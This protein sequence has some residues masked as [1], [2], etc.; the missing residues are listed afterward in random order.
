MTYKCIAALALLSPVA[1]F[2]DF[3]PA[4]PSV[5]TVGQTL[6][7]DNGTISTSGGDIQFAGGKLVPVSN[8]AGLTVANSITTSLG[9]SLIDEATICALA[10]LF[11][12]TPITPSLDAVIAI[13]TNAG[14]YSKLWLTAVSAS[15]VTIQFTTYSSGCS[16]GG[17]GG[18][19][20]GTG[21]STGGSGGT[22]GGPAIAAQGVKN[23][24]S[25]AD[26]R[27]PDGSIAQGSIFVVFGSAMGPSKIQYAGF[28]LPT[29]LS[30]AS[31]SVTVNGTTVPCYM[32]YTLAGQ[33]A[34]V[35]PSDTPVGTG[36]VT[37][38]YNGTPSGTAPITVVK[39]S[40]GIFTVN[41]Q[42][43]GAA[44][45]LDG[46]GNPSSSSF[47]FQ[48][49]EEVVAWGT[50]LGPITGSDNTTPPSGNLPGVTVVV[51]VGGV[52]VT[53]LYAG[54]TGFAG[55]D[56]VN[57]MIPQ[58]VTGCNVPVAITVTNGSSTVTS[59]YVSMAID[60][61][62][63]CASQEQFPP[64]FKTA[65]A[66]GSVR[67]G[68]VLLN[69][70][71]TTSPSVSA[72]GSS[73]TVTVTSDQGEAGFNKLS[74]N[75]YSFSGFD[76]PY[77]ACIIINTPQLGTVTASPLDPGSVIN[78]NGPGGAKQLTESTGV[79]GAFY[80]I[81]GGG[82]QSS[83][84]L[85]F[86]PG[87]YTVNNGNGGKDVGGFNVNIT[88]PQN[89]FTGTNYAS[90]TAV[91]R[92]QSFTVNWTGGDPDWDVYLNGS[93]TVSIG[94]PAVTFECRAHGSDQSL[95]VPVSI[96]QALPPSTTQNGYPLGQLTM[97]AEPSK[98][99]TATVPGLDLFIYSYSVEYQNSVVPF[100]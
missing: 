74:A 48:P 67:V 3:S 58:G 37:V 98:I 90:I 61:T 73:T 91:P 17:T 54:R 32:I 56:Q 89:P 51:T 78:I 29:T 39:S 27:L 26:P 80:N 18:S 94:A 44:V 76:L 81:L 22:P 52:N 99:S 57:F 1:A 71:V 47:A 77:G 41:Q 96:L 11:I 86:T 79:T 63:T 93:S 38:T 88:V 25:F 35:L 92:S 62:L 65:L 9:V 19:T 60:P 85:Y 84:P 72:S 21:G 75:A 10:P 30:G 97:L 83:Q 36:T 24:A 12:S 31:I 95:T 70:S 20:G 7:L 16:S 6:N 42:G 50:G 45:I 100:Q 53:P 64:G 5:L 59:N 13:H 43:A 68:A 4:S 55:E 46:S 15:S 49:G 23:A 87:T 69:R 40:F 66:S 33:L 82:A 34:A 8:A 28:P 2:A 14:H